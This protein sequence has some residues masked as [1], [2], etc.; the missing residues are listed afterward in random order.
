M[1]DLIEI[2]V[3]VKTNS[4]KSATREINS[5]GEGLKSAERSASAFVDAFSRQERQVSKASQAN[6]AYSS[7]AQRMYDDI[8]R[9]GRA[10]KDASES[11][12]VFSK[13]L[14]RQDQLVEQLSLK[15]KPLYA[16][17]KLYERMLS[18]INKAQKLGVLSDTQRKASLEE[19]NR[20]FAAG[21]GAFANYANA[22]GKSANRMGVAMQ[23]TGYQVGD[24]LVQIQSGANPMMAFGQQAT[25]LIGVMYLLPQATLAAKVGFL[26]LQLSLGAI[27]AIISV[28]IPLV[29]AIAAAWMRS[30]DAVSSAKEKV[31]SYSDIMKSTGQAIQEV[32]DRIKMLNLGLKEKAQ[33]DL[34]NG[35]IAANDA[36]SKQ[37]DVIASADVESVS[38]EEAKLTILEQQ[39]EELVKKQDLLNK[40]LATEIALKDLAENR[41]DLIKQFYQNQKDL[42]ELQAQLKSD[43]NEIIKARDT[44]IKQ[45]QD[46]MSLENEAIQYG[47]DSVE[48]AQKKAELDREAYIQQQMSNGILGNNLQTVMDT[49]D[50]AVLV[51]QTLTAAEKAAKDLDS[52]LKSAAS[53]MAQLSNFS[54]GLDVKIAQATAELEALKTGQD[55]ANASMVAGTKLQALQNRDAA[56]AAAVT[57]DQIAEINTLYDESISKIDELGGLNDAIKIQEEANKA[58]AK[59]TK[60]LSKEQK[61]LLKEAEALRKELEGPMV[62]AINGVSNAFGDFISNGLKD[63]KGF[64]KSILNSFKGMISQMISTAMSNKIMLSVGMGGSGLATQAASGQL[65]GVGSAGFGGPMGGLMGTFG[66]GGAAGTGLLG[67]LGTVATGLGTG[68]MSSVYGGIGGMTG[69]VSGGLSVGGLA[70]ISTAIG[71]IAAPLLAVAAVF[72][73]FK[74]KTTELDNG[75]RITVTNMDALVNTFQ[76]VQTKK[77]WGLSKTNSTTESAAS[78]EI[79]SPIVKAVQDMQVQMV[80]AADMFGVSSDAFDNFAYNFELSLKGLTDEQKAQKLNEELTKMGDSFASLTG[81]FQTMNELLEAANQRMGLQNRL[82]QLLGN[83]AA[84]LARQ[85]EAEL[86][87][88]HELNRPMAQ[89]IYGLEDAQTAVTNAFA[90]LRA[91]LDKVISDL[92]SKLTVANEAVNRSRSIFNQLES[93]LSGRYVSGDLASSFARREGAMGFLKSGNLSDEKKLSQA[94]T[95]VSEPTE[96]LFG[97]FVD[98]ARDFALTSLTLEEAKK[99]AQVQLTADEQQVALLEKQIVDADTQYQT[100]IDQYNA[101]LG[102]DTSV[103]SVNE[104]IGTLSVAIQG[105]MSAKAAASAAASAGVG[106]SAG[107]SNIGVQAANSAGAKILAQLGQSGIAVSAEDNAKFQQVNIRGTQQLL[108]VA[109]QL[110]VQ[111]SGQTGAQIQQ[112]LS[113]AG[114]LG[115]SLDDAT[116]A[117]QFAMGGYHNGGMRMVGERGPELEATGPSRIFSHTQTGNMFR[118]PDLKDAVRSLKEEVSGLRSEQRQI[119]MDISKYTKRSYDIERKWDV[120]GLPATRV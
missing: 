7:T 70:G 119:Q 111:T 10:Y 76:T 42:V 54:S 25:Q 26:G 77:F 117:K 57:S 43:V 16:T 19:L 56:L 92:Q 36:I 88:L 93:A 55:A 15:Y 106:S 104:A 11:A 8:L 98:Y 86:A 53:A 46:Q 95:V 100:Q 91:S 44:E 50:A 80:K 28:V 1:A 51:T 34:F 101:L 96:N 107:G 58:A 115:I 35:I 59:A 9:V 33:L 114:N 37:K 112:A 63:F 99:V 71:A 85:R 20:N 105:L 32:T 2:G 103:K 31:A 87:A 21:T 109:K 116:R 69:A 97:S 61:D 23:Q 5:L 79:A 82:D 14:A 74:K 89:A 38:F 52:A 22:A 60:G 48:Y 39:A 3:E 102:I 45:L 17:S 12:S 40:E 81:H 65:A 62:S 27:V 24:F 110:G 108:D 83:N 4:I 13:D 47:K 29:T 67:G 68:F 49:Y 90:G 6:K 72:S 75:L 118:D 84:I 30:S 18:E 64:T 120:E 73:F 78:S 41:L 113:N 66:G 94:L